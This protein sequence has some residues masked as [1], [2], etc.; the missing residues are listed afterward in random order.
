[1]LITV[2]M[3]VFVVVGGGIAGVSCAY[4][5]LE[6]IGKSDSVVLISA[7]DHVKVVKNWVKVSLMYRFL[8]AL[9]RTIC[10]V[11]YRY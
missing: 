10:R 9:D 6:G 3:G 1:M 7:S 8:T 11:F 5:L 4:K 2:K